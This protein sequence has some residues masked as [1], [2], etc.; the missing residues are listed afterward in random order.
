VAK[1]LLIYNCGQCWYARQKRDD[2]EKAFYSV[3]EITG[4][5]MLEVNNFLPSCPLPEDTDEE[6]EPISA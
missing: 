6:E 4:D 1:K 5:Q 2:D 3:C